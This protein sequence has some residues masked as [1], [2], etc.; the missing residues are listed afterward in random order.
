[1]YPLITLQASNKVAIDFD[2]IA[3]PGI[4]RYA[5]FNYLWK[6]TIAIISGDTRANDGVPLMAS[7]QI[8][9][10]NLT[11]STLLVCDGK[12]H[13]ATIIIDPNHW[14]TKVI[15]YQ[16]A[17]FAQGAISPT[18]TFHFILLNTGVGQ[19]SPVTLFRIDN[20]GCYFDNI[21]ITSPAPKYVVTNP[22]VKKDAVIVPY[23]TVIPECVIVPQL[24]ISGRLGETNTIFYTTK[25][26]TNW[27]ELAT[28]V[29]TNGSCYFYDY[30]AEG[31]PQRYYKVAR[32]QE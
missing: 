9:D 22:D 25:I 10:F 21:K 3:N 15:T 17:I 14:P 29:L 24:F 26:N 1:M 5:S 11:G 12:W 27:T 6:Q 30:T 20:P 28:V 19:S 32:Q 7:S 4:L 31:Q 8:K 13:H 18:D 2:Y 16:G 23:K